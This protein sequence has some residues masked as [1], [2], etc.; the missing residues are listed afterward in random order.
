MKGLLLA[1][2]ERKRTNYYHGVEKI[3]LL[4]FLF[5]LF[6]RSFVPCSSEIRV[7]SGRLNANS[8]VIRY[9]TG[10]LIAPGYVDVS[11]LNFTAIGAGTSNYLTSMHDD[12]AGIANKG[13]GNATLKNNV[14]LKNTI[15]G[16]DDRNS[17]KPPTKLQ[18]TTVRRIV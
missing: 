14:T 12:H 7:Y 5:T 8:R 3:H 9:A 15:L 10:Y 11:G 16:G 18:S 6:C 4:L 1:L 17:G 13:G 2:N